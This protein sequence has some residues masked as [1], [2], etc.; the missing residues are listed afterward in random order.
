MA[1]GATAQRV[2]V[3]ETLDGLDERDPA[4][5]RSRRDLRRIHLAMGTRTILRR[6]LVDMIGCDGDGGGDDDR[7]RE[8]SPA[9]HRPVRILELGAG[10][11]SLMLGVAR[12]LDRRWGRV[13]LTLLDRQSL[14]DPAT[15][16][17]YGELGWTAVPRVVDVLAWADQA[18]DACAE[19]AAARW[20]LIVT[21]LFL[22][23]FDGAALARVLGA[24]ERRTE[25]FFACEPRRAPLALAGSHLVGAL[26]ANA[27]TRADAVLSV[28]AGF[29]GDEL[30]RLWPGR[31]DEW[32]VREYRAG[33]FSHCLRADRRRTDFDAQRAR[34]SS[35]SSTW[36]AASPSSPPSSAPASDERATR[37]AGTRPSS[38]RPRRG[39]SSSA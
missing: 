15:V 5:Q 34:S 25:R 23:H 31:A 27:V 13:E 30:T 29:R 37:A 19:S 26:G 7:E 12:A 16:E 11:G 2:V 14:I 9:S 3:A 21:T 38:A 33:L 35:S 4:A 28:H 17:A 22:H 32:Q 20:D 24:V 39:P 1:F 18:S 10:D 36:N 8:P 6:A